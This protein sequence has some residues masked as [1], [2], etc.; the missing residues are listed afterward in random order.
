MY[1]AS[2]GTTYIPN[3]IIMVGFFPRYYL[4]YY[5][6]LAGSSRSP[7]ILHPAPPIHL[8]SLNFTLLPSTTNLRVNP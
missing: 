3:S 4:Y 6:R 1:G 5:L 7:A 2:P 8:N